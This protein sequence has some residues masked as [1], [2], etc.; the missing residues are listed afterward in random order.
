MRISE[1][2]ANVNICQNSSQ[3]CNLGLYLSKI[4]LG[5]LWRFDANNPC[6][7]RLCIST[8]VGGIMNDILTSPVI[9]GLFFILRCLIP[10]GILFGISYLLRRLE[11]VIDHSVEEEDKEARAEVAQQ[12]LPAKP[13]RKTTAKRSSPPKKGS[14]TGGKKKPVTRKKK[15]S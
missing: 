3:D 4:N 11:L 5:C 8:K 12:T 15:E 6:C 9:V 7:K 2:T 14:K 13:A 10:L 1:F